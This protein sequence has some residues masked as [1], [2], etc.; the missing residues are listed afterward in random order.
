MV[1]EDKIKNSLINS[2]QNII[3]GQVSQGASIESLKNYYRN[4]KNFTKLLKDIHYLYIYLVDEESEYIQN[5]KKIF[6]ETMEDLIAANNDKDKK[7]N[8]NVK[9]TASCPHCGLFF[10]YNVNG[11][12]TNCPHCDTIVTENNI[13]IKEIKR[14]DQYFRIN[15]IKIPLIK[16]DAILDNVDQTTTNVYKKVLVTQ[17]KTY[18]EYIDLVDKKKHH[19]KINDVSGDIMRTNKI[20][21]DCIIFNT[22]DLDTIKK[23]IVKYCIGEFISQLPDTLNIFGIDLKPSSFVNKKDLEDSFENTINQQ[24]VINAIQYITGLN[25]ETKLQDFF[26]W[27]NKVNPNIKIQQPQ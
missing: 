1:F 27:S 21:F 24:E 3:D 8:E 17:Y 16:I 4:N 9:G 19:F 2:I 10:Y 23:N 11:N 6:E 15:E 14:W 18:I 13:L 25:Y 22:N 20:T 12:N 26:I 7:I 5:V